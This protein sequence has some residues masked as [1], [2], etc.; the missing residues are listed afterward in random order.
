MQLHIKRSQRKGGVFGGKIY[1]ALDVRAEYSAEE[2]A[3]INKYELGGEL[4]YSSQ[5][6][7]RHFE[8]IDQKLDAGGFR[9]FAGALGSLA[10]AKLNLNITIASLAKGHH[11]ECKDLG[12]LAEAEEVLSNA[13]KNLRG[14][15]QMAQ[16]FNGSEVV[17]DFSTGEPV[18][19]PG[20]PVRSEPK[21]LPPP[22]PEAAS[23]LVADSRDALFRS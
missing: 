19:V 18:P 9:G 14:Y 23:G 2:R 12:E 22:I 11:I 16:S 10:L 13:C 3:D 7:K 17:I 1:F 5:A 8:A 15:L 20:Q 4:V 21:Q 6:A